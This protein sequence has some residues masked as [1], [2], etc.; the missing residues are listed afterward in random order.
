MNATSAAATFIQSYLLVQVTIVSGILE[1]KLTKSQFNALID[2]ASLPGSNQYSASWEGPP[3]P[4]FQAWG[5]L[6]ALDVLNSA[7]AMVA[8]G[9]GSVF[10]CARS[11]LTYHLCY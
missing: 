6:S 1:L 4:S 7:F 9:H 11:T 2:L 10:Y 5:Q 3:E 8:A